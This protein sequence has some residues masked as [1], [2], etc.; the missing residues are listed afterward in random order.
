MKAEQLNEFVD[1]VLS[2]YGPGEIYDMC[3][4]RDEVLIATGMRLGMCRWLRV[5]FEGDTIDREAVRD[6]IESLRADY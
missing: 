5:K 4:T 2:F 1:Y 3:A 6:L